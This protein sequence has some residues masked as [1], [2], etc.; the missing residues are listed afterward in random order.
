MSNHATVSIGRA[1]HTRRDDRNERGGGGGRGTLEGAVMPSLLLVAAMTVSEVTTRIAIVGIVSLAGL[2]IASRIRLPTRR[3]D[4]SG[5]FV[6]PKF[7]RV[8]TDIKEVAE[9]WSESQR[10]KSRVPRAVMVLGMLGLG[11]GFALSLILLAFI[12]EV[13]GSHIAS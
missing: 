10:F 5:G 1:H 2:L 12:A 13:T 8:R 4:Y 11:V 9:N 7:V 6:G 3:N